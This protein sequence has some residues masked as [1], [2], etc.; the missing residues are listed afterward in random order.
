MRSQLSRLQMHSKTAKKQGKQRPVRNSPACHCNPKDQT[1]EAE[2]SA[3]AGATTGKA[4]SI[5]EPA[6]LTQQ[7]DGQG[8][9]GQQVQATSTRQ[10]PQ[11]F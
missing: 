9:W 4:S 8:Q 5:N 2:H 10:A 11:R 3:R 1:V 7:A 6:L